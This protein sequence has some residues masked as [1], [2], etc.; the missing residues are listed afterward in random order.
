MR[1]SKLGLFKKCLLAWVD[2]GSN[3]E[4]PHRQMSI[5]SRSK[6]GLSS[7][8]SHT[9][10]FAVCIVVRCICLEVKQSQLSSHHHCSAAMMDDVGLPSN[11]LPR[12][13]NNSQGWSHTHIA[14]FLY[15]WVSLDLCPAACF[16]P[17][18]PACRG[19][20]LREPCEFMVSLLSAWHWNMRCTCEQI[21]HTF[22]L[23]AGFHWRKLADLKNH[24]N[25]L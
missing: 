4:D 19:R 11:V 6:S 14:S 20:R 5:W 8:H 15:W 7:P 12:R 24:W 22:P 21:I 10:A 16:D 1:F 2:F 13:A 18:I 25:Q 9:Q 17:L 23:H 3:Q